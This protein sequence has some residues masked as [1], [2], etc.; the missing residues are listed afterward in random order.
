MPHDDFTVQPDGRGILMTRREILQA[1]AAVA[2][3]P[4]HAASQSR[5]SGPAAPAPPQL[6][7]LFDYEELAR[8]RLPAM[9]YE[10]IAG[11]AG[12]EVTLRDNR[13]Q[14]DAIKLKPRVL[15][16]VSALDT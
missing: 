6:V 10:Y 9:A 16:D 2:A 14:F 8:K 1:L 7:N 4:A 5:P 15:R 11:G 12:D 13:A 3:L